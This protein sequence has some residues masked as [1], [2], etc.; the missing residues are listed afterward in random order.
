MKRRLGELVRV[1]SRAVENKPADLGREVVGKGVQ[2]RAVTCD[3]CLRAR[4]Q[5]RPV[6]DR[7]TTLRELEQILAK[8]RAADPFKADVRAFCATGK[9]TRIRIDGYIPPVKVQ[10]LIKQM[11][12]SEPELPIERIAVQGASGC[13]DFVGTVELR[14]V[15]VTH[16]Y[17]FGWCCRWRAIEEGWTDYFGFPDQIRAAQEFDWRC[18]HTWKRMDA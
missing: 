3:I 10:R 11:L 15:S 13:S 1:C 12:S 4:S 8:S 9:A 18:F 17:D 6:S 2:P 16:V 5:P 14:T 7:R